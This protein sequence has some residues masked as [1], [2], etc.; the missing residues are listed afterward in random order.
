MNQS[1]PG[2]EEW[3]SGDMFRQSRPSIELRCISLV[4][5]VE[6]LCWKGRRCCRG[7]LWGE[8]SEG[9]GGGFSCSRIYCLYGFFFFLSSVAA[10]EELKEKGTDAVGTERAFRK[11]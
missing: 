9:T 3:D 5:Q 4:K 1:C 6:N 8:C 11:N 10:Y 2:K 7:G